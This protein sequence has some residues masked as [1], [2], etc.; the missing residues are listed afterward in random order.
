MADRSRSVAVR[1]SATV[2]GYVANI[3][4][5]KATTVDFHK[6]AI[7]YGQKHQAQLDELANKAAMLGTG[8]VALAGFAVKSAMDWESAWAGVTKTIEGTPAQLA[9][10]EQG[11]L[12]MSTQL[13]T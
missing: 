9:A 2:T 4:A 5:A 11:L 10:I 3:K 13:P 6:N 7:G 8:M 1:L 12:D